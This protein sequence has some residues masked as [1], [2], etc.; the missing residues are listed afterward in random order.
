[1]S[2][3]HSDTLPL[4]KCLSTYRCLLGCLWP[5][6]FK[7]KRPLTMV[8]L[9]EEGNVLPFCRW[10]EGKVRAVWSPT[11]FNSLLAQPLSPHYQPTPS[12]VTII[13]LPLTSLS[14]HPSHLTISPPPLTSLSFH[15]LSRHYHST[16]SQL[17]I[18]SP[19]SP[20]YQHPLTLLSAHPFSLHYQLTPL[21]PEYQPT[22]IHL[23]I[24]ST[25]YQPASSLL[26]NSRPPLTWLSVDLHT[27]VSSP[28]LT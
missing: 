20:H 7:W 27:P 18:S 17:T 5:G 15:S 1:M 14:F 10:G 3:S 9:R 22:S 28:P 26:I 24:C 19:L 25:H 8:A 12:H 16:P 6:H 13:S 11:P 21:A 4:S 23:T 2:S